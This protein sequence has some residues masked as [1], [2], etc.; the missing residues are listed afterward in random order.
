MDE[1]QALL[2][3]RIYKTLIT[4][5]IILLAFRLWM[6]QVVAE[7]SLKR[8]A[9]GNRIRIIETKAERGSIYDSKGDLLVGNKLSLNLTISPESSGKSNI[10]KDISK[11]T[12]ITV[13][14]IIKEIKKQ[15]KKLPP[16]APRRIAANLD[17]KTATRIKEMDIAGVDIEAGSYRKY[18]KKSLASHIL[19]YIGEISEYDTKK[20]KVADYSYGDSIGKFGLERGYESI[21]KGQKGG[22]Q[23]E[24]DASGKKSRIINKIQPVN[25]HSL[26]LTIDSKIQKAA[27]DVLADAIKNAKK[28]GNWKASSGAVVVLDPNNGQLVA[29]ASYPTFDPSYFSGNVNYSLKKEYMQMLNKKDS[30]FPMFNRATMAAYPPGSTF[31]VVSALAGLQKGGISQYTSYTCKGKWDKFDDKWAK[32]CW[33]KRGHGRVSLNRAIEQSCNIY[34]YEVGYKFYNNN[35]EDLQYFARLLGLGNLTG[36]D[37][38]GEKKGRIPDAKWKREWNKN[39]PEFQQWLPGDSVNLAVGQGDVLATPLQMASIYS[40]IANGGTIYKPY[41]VK[42]IIS[43]EGKIVREIKPTIIRKLA[44]SN[45]ISLVGQGLESVVKRGTGEGAFNG[46][47]IR[48]AGKTGTSQIKGKDDT[49]W[50][51]GYGPLPDSKY[52]VAMVIEEGGSGGAVSAPAVRRLFGEIYKLPENISKI[53][54]VK[55]FSR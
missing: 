15:E 38:P 34:F 10:L 51:V 28:Q 47:P 46:F 52:V 8:L 4:V 20:I 5:A 55:D 11:I 39:S 26:G 44:F 23:I 32:W 42:R 22:M 54:G 24:I 40:A 3:A 33:N 1:E 41:I 29:M 12:G 18:S 6:L 21:L 37:L 17:I 7:S 9:E 13:K 19:G 53:K 48:I 16:L 50:F 43:S 27:E 31:K 30:K 2:R 25:G 35:S 49:S 45:S 14:E 36:I